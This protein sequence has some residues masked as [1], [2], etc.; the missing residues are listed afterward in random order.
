MKSFFRKENLFGLSIW[1]S[2][3]LR[4]FLKIIARH[5]LRSQN[6]CYVT[7]VQQKSKQIRNLYRASLH[8]LLLMAQFLGQ[9]CVIIEAPKLDQ[10]PV[11]FFVISSSVNDV[12]V[13][14]CHIKCS[15]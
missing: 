7:Y 13:E 14:C 12:S 1:K 2:E 15:A 8:R 5:N 4:D 9:P 6:L 10:A 11:Y 3:E